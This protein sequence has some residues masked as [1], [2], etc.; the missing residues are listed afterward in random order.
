MVVFYPSTTHSSLYS[1]IHALLQWAAR[2]ATIRL[3]W[4]L[5]R[6]GQWQ[7]WKLWLSN[8]EILTSISFRPCKTPKHATHRYVRAFLSLKYFCMHHALWFA[9]VYRK[10][11][12]CTARPNFQT[13]FTTSV[14]GMLIS[15]HWCEVV[16]PCL[17][18]SWW[19]AVLSLLYPVRSFVDHSITVTHTRPLSLPHF[20][21][22][23]LG[24][25]PL[26]TSWIRRREK[27]AWAWHSPRW[28]HYLRT[29]KRT[30]EIAGGKIGRT[31]TYLRLL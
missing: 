11:K 30:D 27:E 31:R 14:S 20:P 1:G 10:L 22:F 21:Y 23:L 26:G 5:W 9:S 29:G 15:I 6:K 4:K 19:F 24:F 18:C 25:L 7:L 16:E 2:P 13:R 12:A 17:E 28:R 8:I 3:F